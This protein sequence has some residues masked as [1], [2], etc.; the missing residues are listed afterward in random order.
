MA[1]PVQVPASQEASS[2]REVAVEPEVAAPS[3]VPVAPPERTIRVF[4][5]STFRDMQA[6]RDELVKRVF[7][8][9]RKLCEA[10]GGGVD[11][12]GPALGHHRRG[13]RPKARCCRSAWTRSSAAGRTSSACWASATAGCPA[14]RRFPGISWPTEPWLREHRTHSV[15]ELEILHGV[16]NNPG[17]ADHA[18]F[19]FRDPAYLERLPAGENPADFAGESPRRRPGSPT[20]RAG[21]VRPTLPGG[22]ASRPARAT[23][24]PRRSASRCSRTSRRSSRSFTRKERCPIRSTRR[25]HA[26]RPT[27]AAA[28]W[29]SSA[30]RTSCRSWRRT[31][32]RPARGRPC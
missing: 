12:G 20:S 31:S 30:A 3:P 27:R 5:S 32:A 14:S 17:M 24:R 8:Q 1:R 9:L 15:T 13:R 21:S 11:R 22:S 29:R 7:P 2:L 19:Y 28:A 6:E 25:R 4:I 10:R 23:P 16:L 18:F 26:T